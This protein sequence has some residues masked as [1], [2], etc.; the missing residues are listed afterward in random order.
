MLKREVILI[1]FTI[2]I[3]TSFVQAQRCSE[4]YLDKYKCNNNILQRQYQTINCDKLWKNYED[5][6]SKNICPLSGNTFYKYTCVEEFFGLTNQA[7][8]Q[9]TQETCP[10]DKKCSIWGCIPEN[11]IIC[12]DGTEEGRCSSDSLKG[13]GQP[14]ECKNQGLVDNCQRCGCQEGAT[15]NPADNTCTKIKENKPPIVA[16]PNKIYLIEN[17]KIENP[18]I[19][20]NN[21]AQDPEARP[22]Q[23]TIIQE[24]ILEEYMECDLENSKLVCEPPRKEGTI[25]LSIE[26]SD[27]INKNEIKLEIEIFPR[28]TFGEGGQIT[29][30]GLNSPPKAEAGEDIKSFP[31]QRIILDGTRSYDKD[32]NI[33]DTT[34]AYSWYLNKEIIAQGKVIEYKFQEP[35][36]YIIFL[37]VTDSKGA[38]SIDKL[39]VTVAKKQKCT[40]TNTPY[41][42]EDTICNQ[43]W[44]TQE[45]ETLNIN[46]EISSCNLFEICDDTT[47]YIIEEAISCCKDNEQ[48]EGTKQS[49]CSYSRRKSGD[50]LKKCTSLYI[51]KSLGD[52][53]IYLNDY[54]EAEMC[55]YGESYLCR[56]PKNLF[57]AKPLPNTRFDLSKIRCYTT[58]SVI[59]KGEWLSDTRI[60]RNNIALADF[61]SHVTLNKLGTGTCVDYSTALTTLI[62]K[63][64]YKKDE[65]YTVESETHAYNLIRFPYDKKYTI[66]DT[67]GNN[68]PSFLFGKTPALSINSF[69]YCGE[70]KKCYN[71]RG[72]TLCP[73]QDKIYGCEN[74]KISLSRKMYYS[75]LK[76]K[77]SISDLGGD[78]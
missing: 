29:L 35:G 7:S 5:C 47:D 65:I 23:Y 50:S 20:F 68:N 55:C 28:T 51:I 22:L 44:P 53:A 25:L 63:L 15:C 19:D 11:K 13:V 42:P 2:L 4:G 3:L 45:G 60:D 56:D 27:E 57:K 61:P 16:K 54:F 78:N 73:P 43:K 40:Q 75:I 49:L 48:L 74:T 32:N 1:V 62:R 67:T 9:Q 38:S 76:I 66:I 58:P 10:N 6:S 70:I 59:K 39:K 18:L 36:A 52:N 46:S 41:F 31:N 71:D 72:E 37:K 17:Q 30:T 26:V 69:D 8:C 33:P 24:E 77:Q 12:K 14:K 64:G 21:Y 34:E